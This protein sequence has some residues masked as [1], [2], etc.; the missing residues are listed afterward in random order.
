MKKIFH[1]KFDVAEW[2]QILRGR[3]FS[4]FVAFS[5]YPNFKRRFQLRCSFFFY[6]LLSLIKPVIHNCCLFLFFQKKYGW[7]SMECWLCPRFFILQLS[8]MQFQNKRRWIISV[9][10]NFLASN[11]LCFIW[12]YEDCRPGGKIIFENKTTLKIKEILKKTD[13]ERVFGL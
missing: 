2:R 6:S 9:P 13:P 8:R 1:L 11:V 7:K 3:F 4:N 10:C 12:W 5:E